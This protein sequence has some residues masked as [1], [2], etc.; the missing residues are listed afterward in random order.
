MRAKVILEHVV[1]R[2]YGGVNAFF[3]CVYDNSTE[4]NKRF[5]KATPSGHIDLQID[6]PEVTKKLVIGQ[7]YYVDFTPVQATNLQKPVPPITVGKY[8]A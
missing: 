6:N 1:S 4:E 7:D 5:T 2:S 8:P 3:R